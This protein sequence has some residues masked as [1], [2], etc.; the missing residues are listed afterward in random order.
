MKITVKTCL[1]ARLF[2]LKMSV[3]LVTVWTASESFVQ[4]TFVP[5][6]IFNVAGSKTYLP[7][8]ARIFTLTTATGVREGVELGFVCWVEPG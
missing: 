7:F 3:S 2:V 6:L 8:F 5:A 1:V 4:I